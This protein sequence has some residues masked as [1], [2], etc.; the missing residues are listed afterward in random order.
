MLIF[1][2]LVELLKKCSK[3]IRGNFSKCLKSRD[4]KTR[5]G[6]EAYTLPK[7][8]LLTQMLFLENSILNRAVSGHV[9][10]NSQ[11]ISV[12]VPSIQQSNRSSSSLSSTRNESVKGDDTTNVINESK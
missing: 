11:S 3:N 9:I 7:C 1:Y 4:R 12:E 6:A 8:E 5:S 2:F 10:D